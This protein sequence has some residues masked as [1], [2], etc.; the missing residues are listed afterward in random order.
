MKNRD[1]NA[2]RDEI[3]A[4][5]DIGTTIGQLA[6]QL[7]QNVLEQVLAEGAHVVG[8]Y[9]IEIGIAAIAYALEDKLPAIISGFHPSLNRDALVKGAA[10]IAY[11]EGEGQ[12]SDEL[13]VGDEVIFHDPYAQH[14]F[15]KGT[16]ENIDESGIVVKSESGTVWGPFP[17]SYVQRFTGQTYWRWA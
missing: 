9:D 16:V 7:G 10:K 2:I 6:D 4:D 15:Q 17:E 3:V 1:I 12:S 8:R 13:A 5:R 14:E 11:E